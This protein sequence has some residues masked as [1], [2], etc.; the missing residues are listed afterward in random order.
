MLY[1]YIVYKYFHNNNTNE[2]VYEI[3]VI[4]IIVGNLIENNYQIYQENYTNDKANH[5]SYSKK[6]HF[7]KNPTIIAVCFL[8]INV[9]S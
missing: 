6:N 8:V 1:K 5:Y 3:K 7:G 9:F 4:R 2:L